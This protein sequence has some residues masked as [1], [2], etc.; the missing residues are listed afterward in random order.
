MARIAAVYRLLFA[1][2]LTIPVLAQAH[3]QAT[4]GSLPFPEYS[5]RPDPRDCVGFPQCGGYFLYEI[6]VATPASDKELC[7]ADFPFAG[8]VVKSMCKQADG[9]LVEFIPS[10]DKPTVGSIEADPDYKGYDML[11]SPSCEP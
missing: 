4:E 11:V 3:A 9:T 10:C 2:V 8:Y 5:V 1:F 6:D 7:I